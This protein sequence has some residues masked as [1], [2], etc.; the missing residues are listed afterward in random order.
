MLDAGCERL[1]ELGDV[2]AAAARV[3]HEHEELVAGLAR[4][5]VGRPGDGAQAGG[6]VAQQVVTGGMAERVV[7]AA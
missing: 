6:D 4:D 7:H 5:H 1:G 2:A 3:A